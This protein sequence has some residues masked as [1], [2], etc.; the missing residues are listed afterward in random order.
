M[1]PIQYRGEEKSNAV[2][3]ALTER[4]PIALRTYTPTQAVL[5]KSAGIFHWTAEGRQL[6]DYSSG[7]LVAN[8]GHNP[9][10]WFQRLTQYMQWPS[11]FCG[12]VSAPVDHYT[13]ALA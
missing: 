1:T 5:A 10:R 2:R 13:P 6:Y 3:S 11:E 4:E 7:V 12:E 9:T 8:L